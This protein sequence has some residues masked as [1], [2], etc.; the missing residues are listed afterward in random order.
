MPRD[1]EQDKIISKQTK[2]D[3]VKKIDTHL[4]RAEEYSR[5]AVSTVN[6][7]FNGKKGK[8]VNVNNYGYYARKAFIDS[9]ITARETAEL[10][11]LKE[12]INKKPSRI[13]PDESR[14]RKQY[15]IQNLLKSDLNFIK[16]YINGPYNNACIALEIGTQAAIDAEDLVLQSENSVHN[17]NVESTLTPL[18]TIKLDDITLGNL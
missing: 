6:T 5:Y 2:E 16:N 3:L 18:I 13:T 14:Y 12:I 11:K 9:G 4:K 15:G 7:L 10:L 17:V 8:T 1:F